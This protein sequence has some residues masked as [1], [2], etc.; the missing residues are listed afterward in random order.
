VAG[1]KTYGA[2]ELKRQVDGFAPV[3]TQHL[4]DEIDTLIKLEKCDGEKIKQAMKETAD[5]GAKT[6]N[7]VRTLIP[8]IA[9]CYCK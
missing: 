9:T 3:L 7:P 8:L 6:A 4:H 5:E 1:E 2:A